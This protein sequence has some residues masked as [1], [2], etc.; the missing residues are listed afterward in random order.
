M[1]SGEIADTLKRERRKAERE[2]AK[3][4]K[5]V[6]YNCRESG[7]LLADCP[8]GHKG[9]SDQEERQKSCFKCGSEDHTSKDCKTKTKPGAMS[10]AFATCFICKEQGHLA[11]ACPDNPKGLYPKG[12]GCRFCGSVEHLK[13]DCPRKSQK[14]SKLEVKL[15]T[16][17]SGKGV[18][19]V[20]DDHMKVKKAK[21]VFKEQKKVVHF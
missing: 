9:Q 18:E 17:F 13:A 19:D 3:Y 12:G 14:D 7:H 8:Q 2:L 11:K 6:C 10:Y 20:E 15:D 16:L 5:M 21:K 1:S 4:N